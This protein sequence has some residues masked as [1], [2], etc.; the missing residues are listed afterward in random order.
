MLDF[1]GE[2]NLPKKALLSLS[3]RAQPRRKREGN[4]AKEALQPS[5]FP[6]LP[7]APEGQQS[8]ALAS[9]SWPSKV[10]IHNWETSVPK[11]AS[12]R[13]HYPILLE[14]IPPQC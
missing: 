6:W 14:S 9:L 7:L 4:V 8:Q 2:M 1:V 13:P 10:E 5:P 11:T 3:S 12:E